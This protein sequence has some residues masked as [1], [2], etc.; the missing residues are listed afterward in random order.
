MSLKIDKTLAASPN[1]ERGRPTQ[2]STDPKGERIAYAS[3]KSIFLRSLDDPSL[4]KQYTNHTAQTT[5]A[6]F[7]PSGFYV[8]SGDVSGA[9]KVWDAVEGVN[10]KGDYHI[11]SGR[12]NDIAWDGD[13]QRIIAVGDG[14]E[15]FGHC[16][17][18]DSGNSVGEISGHS[19]TINTVSIRQQRPLRAATG[20]DD[21]SMVFLHGAPFKF[22][23]KMG[24]LHKGYV[25][26][27]GFSPDGN[28]LVSVGADRRIQ[29]YDGKTGE[30]TVKIGDGEHK[31]SIF[32]VSW[33]RDSKRFV[34]A[35]ADQTVKLWDV[36]A[37]KAVQTWRFG[38]EGPVSIPDHQVGVVWPAGRSDGMV[39]SL[40]LAGDLNYLV[41]GSQKPT[42]VVQ[43]HNRSIT[44]LGSSGEGE[45]QTFWTG[46]FD[47][48]VCSWDT[49]SGLA[50]A[51]EG[52]TH[53]NQVTAFDTTSSRAYSVGWD[54]TLRIADTSSNTIL[55]E[56]SK[57]S[58][59][60]KGLASAVGRVYV[61][62]VSGIDI[63]ANDALVGGL[64]TKDFT[65]TTIAASGSWVAVGDDANVVHI[66]TADG[67]KI[68]PKE[69]LTVSTAQITALK[70]SPNGAF[71][72]AGNSSG[73]IIVYDTSSWEVKT[74]R[75]SAHS[76]RVTSISWN[77]GSTLAVSGGLD[78]NV[79]IWSLKAPGKRVKSP[80]AHK[81]G[82]NGVCWVDGD[83]KVASTGGDAALKIWDVSGIE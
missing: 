66:Y 6:R 33:A 23:T 82:V 79:F 9:V 65:P 51:V 67:D 54:D 77:A 11:I 25:N 12:I 60:P 47:G 39:V 10:T 43:G 73:K 80:N 8:A 61:A 29:L 15:R 27:V 70:F 14:R 35:S 21:S 59:Q 72:A 75:W 78:T 62:T 64:T 36:E 48:R 74:D 83:K 71:L 24:G 20:A 56:T 18:A 17:T 28:H 3:G 38:G 55:G 52:Q 58:A 13:S 76:A 1:T 7:S 2:L 46:S 69:K 32:G 45:S 4:S 37:G 31:G 42:K 40:N 34:T 26:G 5:V 44:A 57:L 50:T 81:D 63:F 16:I 30:P 19:S 49:S 53:S 68:S 22:A 41:E